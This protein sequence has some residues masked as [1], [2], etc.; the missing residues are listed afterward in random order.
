MP[1]DKLKKVVSHKAVVKKQTEFQKLLSNFITTDASTV[2]DYVINDI[3]IPLIKRGISGTVDMILYG[4]TMPRNNGFNVGPSVTRIS[5]GGVVN[6]TPNNQKVSRNRTVG[7]HYD[8]EN[9]IFETRGDAQAVLDALVYHLNEFGIVNV[10]A[11]YDFADVETSNYM[12]NKFGWIDL[13][14]SEVVRRL[15][16]GYSLK[17]PKPSP[18]QQIK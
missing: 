14:G 18:I 16:G 1:E 10:S 5:Y 12:M 6:G 17:L 2:K 7:E 9:I 4:K 8:Y 15:D 13:K 11:L 3:L